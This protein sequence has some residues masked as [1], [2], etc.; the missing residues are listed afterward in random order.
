MSQFAITIP[1]KAEA[2]T[3]A[4]PPHMFSIKN[5][6]SSET[7]YCTQL[8]VPATAF[9]T[10]CIANWTAVRHVGEVQNV[11]TCTIKGHSGIEVKLHS[12][13]TS[14][15]D[16][17]WSNSSSDRFTVGERRPVAFQYA[18]GW[19]QSWS[20]HCEETNNIGTTFHGQPCHCTDWATQLH[21]PADDTNITL[22]QP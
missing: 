20:G 8:I 13:L 11:S 1:L 2:E 21:G 3:S 19:A 22:L 15:L 5:H 7:K 12:F 9:V 17:N 10:R 6:S 14:A 18:A 4:P 16:G